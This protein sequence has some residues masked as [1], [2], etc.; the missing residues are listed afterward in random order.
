MP[1]KVCFINETSMSWL[2]FDTF[3]D[4]I[5]LTDIVVVLNSPFIDE[6]K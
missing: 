1:F 6:K 5:F 4:A 2:V 3:I